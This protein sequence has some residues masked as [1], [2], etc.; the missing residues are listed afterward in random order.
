MR[1]PWLT[2]APAR[3][4]GPTGR[5]IFKKSYI[6]SSYIT[7]TV[8]KSGRRPDWKSYI[9]C[10]YITI[11]YKGMYN[12]CSFSTIYIFKKYIIYF[13]FDL[14]KSIWT[15]NVFWAPCDFWNNKK[16]LGFFFV[17]TKKLELKN[18]IFS[19][20]RK[21]AISNDFVHTFL[22]NGYITIF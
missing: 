1:A 15:L 20:S 13:P 11:F 22:K 12:N 14:P 16:K 17:K 4:P 10:A 8:A 3:E 21:R 9:C 18:C 7:Y 6:C 5:V 2:G 19:L